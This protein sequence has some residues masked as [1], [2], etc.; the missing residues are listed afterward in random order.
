MGRFG[1][2]LTTGP[3]ETA[4]LFRTFARAGVSHL[5][6]IV[7]P[8]TVEGIEAFAPVLTALDRGS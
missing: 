8:H 4:D 5:Q 7:W 3:D 6:V 1:P 2:P